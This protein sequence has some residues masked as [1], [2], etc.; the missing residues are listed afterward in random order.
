MWWIWINLFFD[1]C[2]RN[3]GIW[4]RFGINLYFRLRVGL[5]RLSSECIFW[6][7]RGI[8]VV[9]KIL[10]I[11]CRDW[12]YFGVLYFCL[13]YSWNELLRVLGKVFYVIFF[14]DVSYKFSIILIYRKFF[15]FFLVRF[16]IMFCVGVLLLVIVRVI[17]IFCFMD[18]F[19]GNIFK[20]MYVLMFL[21][22]FLL[23]D[24]RFSCCNLF[25]FVMMEVILCELMISFNYLGNCWVLVLSMF[26][27]FVLVF[28]YLFNVL[29]I[30]YY[31]LIGCCVSFFKGLRI[32]CLKY[33]FGFWE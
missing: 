16:E 13:K 31:G 12:K 17:F 11:C 19:N 23:L 6:M 14:V 32:V 18:F 8:Y 22:F 28:V 29:I 4:L 9:I 21:R 27:I 26:R 1:L 7:V 33:Y 25:M 5:L 10:K 15:W 3:K 20:D 24:C 30:I 2:Y